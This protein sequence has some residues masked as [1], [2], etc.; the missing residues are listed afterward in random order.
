[1]RRNACIL[2]LL[3][4][5]AAAE[6]CGVPVDRIND[7][8]C[9]SPDGCDEPNT[10]A[11][12]TVAAARRFECPDEGSGTTLIPASRIGDG[13]CDCCDGSDEVSGCEDDCE[14]RRSQAREKEE[15]ERAAEAAGVA[16]RKDM[17][18][19]AK[20]G[21]EVARRQLAASERDLDGMQAKIDAAREKR[22]AARA[23][24]D[25]LRDAA[26]AKEMYR[27]L[28]L[29]ALTADQLRGLVVDLAREANQGDALVRLARVANGLPEAEEP[30]PEPE[31]EQ[32]PEPEPE[33][34][35]EAEPEPEPEAAAPAEEQEDAASTEEAEEPFARTLED[36]DGEY[37]QTLELEDEDGDDLPGESDLD[38]AEAAADAED[39]AAAADDDDA[40]AEFDAAEE[41]AEAGADADAAADEAYGGFDEGFDEDFD[42]H[43]YD[44]Y[45]DFPGDADYD[46]DEEREGTFADLEDEDFADDEY[47][48]IPDDVF[49]DEYPP[50]PSYDD[51]YSYDEGDT[52]L[53]LETYR[54]SEESYLS[55]SKRKKLEAL[56]DTLNELERA[57]DDN[58]DKLRESKAALGDA[59]YGDDGARWALRDKCVSRTLQGYL[60]EVCF[61]KNARQGSTRLGDYRSTDGSVLT[62]DGGEYCWNGPAR[63]LIVNLEC[64]AANELV[65]VDEP[66][67]CVY[68]AIVRTPAVCGSTQEVGDE[69]APPPESSGGF[70]RFLGLG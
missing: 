32:E 16:A 2:A 55:S 57:R 19:A 12:S 66:R 26:A 5:T 63:S 23:E 44:D 39:D 8:Y 52:R 69:C 54:D 20:R 40:F 59:D 29:D 41:E 56:E 61:Y 70:L 62:Y 9:D 24:A 17:A 50:T 68:Q 51:D 6:D 30:E 42:D 45:D 10:S 13:V 4:V 18:C 64:G 65:S 53:A 33:A 1:M 28:H 7:D 67:T 48:D 60:Y 34:E 36:A 14:A 25:E 11:C 47:G 46:D 43:A 3:W 31:A 27:A 22:D 35:P 21:R 58:E 37:V 49:P 38:A 15:A